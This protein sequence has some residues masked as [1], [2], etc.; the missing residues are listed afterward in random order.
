MG[1]RPVR[2]VMAGAHSLDWLLVL[3]RA[4]MGVLR[5]LQEQEQGQKLRM[6]SRLR[7]VLRSVPLVRSS[8]GQEETWVQLVLQSAVVLLLEPGQGHRQGLTTKL[9]PETL[10]RYLA[11]PPPRL[12]LPA[13]I[14]AERSPPP[15]AQTLLVLSIRL[16]LRSTLPQLPLL[17]RAEGEDVGTEVAGVGGKLGG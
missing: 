5:L 9:I 1:E 16:Q 13:P 14:V 2:T 4:V 3:E 15:Q 8:A 11:N 7:T 17:H 6:K 10:Q 12:L